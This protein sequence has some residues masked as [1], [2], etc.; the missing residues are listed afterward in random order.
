[1]F[2]LKC[3]CFQTIV[4]K[5]TRFQSVQPRIGLSTNALISLSNEKLGSLKGCVKNS[6]A[7]VEGIVVH[8]HSQIIYLR[9]MLSLGILTVFLF[10]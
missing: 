10:V 1:M 7:C 5:S 2:A 9:Q 8:S 6:G 4:V 3:V